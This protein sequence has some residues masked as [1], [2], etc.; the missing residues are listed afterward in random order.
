MCSKKERKETGFSQLNLNETSCRVFSDLAQLF[1][2][3]PHK[4]SGI[5]F[6]FQAKLLIFHRYW[7]EYC[8]KPLY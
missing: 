3:D 6:R 7:P 4:L 8:I 2:G 5:Y 1:F